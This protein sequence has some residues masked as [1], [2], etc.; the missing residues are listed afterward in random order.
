MHAARQPLHE[1]RARY[2]KQMWIGRMGI[3]IGILV[4]ITDIFTRWKHGASLLTWNFLLT[5]VLT[6]GGVLAAAYGMG[7][8]F[9][10]SGF[11]NSYSDNE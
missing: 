10:K 8:I 3:P 4:V 9:W 6:I 1:Q 2:I 11:G 7:V 5:T